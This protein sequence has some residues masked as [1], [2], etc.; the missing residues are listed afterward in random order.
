MKKTLALILSLI[1][2]LSLSACL[3]SGS[4]ESTAKEEESRSPES[5]EET[6]AEETTEVPETRATYD[7]WLPREYEEDNRGLL[8]RIEFPQRTCETGMDI[9]GTLL[10]K[11][12][13]GAP[14]NSYLNLYVDIFSY[15]SVMGDGGLPSQSLEFSETRESYVTTG[16]SGGELLPI[17]LSEG[18]EITVDFTIEGNEALFAPDICTFY[19]SIDLCENAEYQR[20]EVLYG[21]YLPISCQYV[22]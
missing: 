11:N 10:L 1:W 3:G 16:F 6:T 15:S 13:T 5:S 7:S 14:L 9:K 18:E 2:M 22:G 8:L 19:F 4:E 20:N 21:F 17:T 12:E